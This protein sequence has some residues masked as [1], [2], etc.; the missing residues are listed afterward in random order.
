MQLIKF[1]N[2]YD[3]NNVLFYLHMTSDP[4]LVISIRKKIV[5]DEIARNESTF[6][7]ICI[8]MIYVLKSQVTWIYVDSRLQWLRKKNLWKIYNLLENHLNLRFSSIRYLKF[9]VHSSKKTTVE[10]LEVWKAENS[11][12]TIIAYSGKCY[13]MIWSKLIL[14]STEFS[15]SSPHC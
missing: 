12:S 10:Q 2:E 5:W 1:C 7:Y 9:A 13:A 11:I 14:F 8:E 6:I 4:C 15:A 3:I